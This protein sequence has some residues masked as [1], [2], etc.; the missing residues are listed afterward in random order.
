MCGGE[1]RSKE[2]WGMCF[3]REDQERNQGTLAGT[4]MR[5]TYPKETSGS[6]LRL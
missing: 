2:R 4:N 5:K 3:I 6:G 1:K